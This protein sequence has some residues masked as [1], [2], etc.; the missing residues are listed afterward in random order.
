MTRAYYNEHDPFAAAWL[1]ELIAEG[2]IAPGDVDERDIR[3]VA[4]DDLAGYTQCH[5]FAGIGGWSY[6]LR[7]A[8]WPDDRP[9]WTGSAP[10]Q[11]FSAAG[12]GGGVLDERHLWPAFHW[13]IAQCRPPVVAGEQVDAA[14]RHGWLDLVR[15][16]LEAEGYAV[17]VVDLPAACV[18]APHIRQRLWW[19]ADANSSG[20]GRRPEG[21]QEGQSESSDSGELADAPRERR[22]GEH[23]L[24][25]PEETRREPGDHPE[26]P[27]GR[28]AG[29]LGDTDDPRPQGR[30]ECGDGAGQRAAGETGVGSGVA[31]ADGG[32]SCDGHLQRSGE[33]AERAQDAA[34]GFWSDAIWLHCRDG[35]ARPVEPGIF[36]LA[37]GVPNRVGTL[38]GAGNA[39]VAPLA[40]EFIKA[41]RE[42]IGEDLHGL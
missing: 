22:T 26:A 23:A 15:A 35:K 18:G 9:I 7:L 17:G 32:Q 25:R 24:L 11:P 39:I 34:A 8:G 19:V 5:F 28:D 16:D 12:R 6:A 37:H 40:A 2:A 33:H 29:E 21:V 38:R 1:R 14:I 3:D 36:P 42:A 10:C 27:G 31:D 4:P 20:A 41:Y 30:G 13:L